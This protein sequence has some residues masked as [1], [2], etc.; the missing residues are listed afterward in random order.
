MAAPD[1]VGSDEI[2]KVVELIES[3]MVNTW[4]LHAKFVAKQ[5]ALPRALIDNIRL[6]HVRK[7]ALDKRKDV[8]WEGT[9]VRV[10][11]DNSAVA[12][13]LKKEA[14][15]VRMKAGEQAAALAEPLEQAEKMIEGL[16]KESGT[17]V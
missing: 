15:V 10:K 12:L 14:L 11:G 3:L 1:Q 6:Q 2:G 5:T 9:A 4:L 16:D 17:A 13:Q 8:A 7:K